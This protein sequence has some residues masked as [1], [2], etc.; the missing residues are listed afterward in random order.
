MACDP[1]T[2]ISSA[3]LSDLKK[4]ITTIDTVVESSLDT[5]VTKDGKTIN[6]LSGQLKLLGFIPPLVYTSGIVFTTSDT[7]KTVVE[8]G[9]VY[10]PNPAALPFTTSGTFIG[11]DDARFFVVQGLTSFSTELILSAV[12][13][14]DMKSKD[15]QSGQAI[16]TQGYGSSGDGGGDKYLIQT[17]VEFGG[18]PNE[19]DEITLNNGN[20]AVSLSVVLTFS[21]F[22]FVFGGVTDNPAQ[23]TAILNKAV[24]T[25]YPI[26]GENKLVRISGTSSL[27]PT[28]KF[29]LSN[30]N[31]I[32]GND[33]TDQ[34]N[35]NF[36]TDVEYVFENIVVDGERNTRAELEPWSVFSSFGGYDSI[37]P[38]GVGSF[39]KTNPY[40]TNKTTVKNITFNNCHYQECMEL[41]SYGVVAIDNFES[42][43]CSYKTY[44][45]W[46][47]PDAGSD[48]GTGITQANRITTRDCGVMVNDFLVDGVAKTRADAFA[49]QGA[50]GAIVTFGRYE[51][52]NVFV[53][54]YGS[55]G[56]TGD[57]NLSWSCDNLQIIHDDPNAFSNNPSGAYWNES[58]SRATGN[59]IE[60][61]VTARD[62]RETPIDNSLV[63]IYLEN[64]EVSELSDLILETESG[65]N[66]NKVIRGS[67]GIGAS[68]QVNN[69]SIEGTGSNNAIVIAGLGGQSNLVQL[70]NGR[71]RGGDIIIRDSLNAIVTNCDL[72]ELLQ[73]NDTIGTPI[74]NITLDN[75]QA[76]NTDFDDCSGIIKVNACDLGRI[77]MAPGSGSFERMTVDGGTH[78]IFNSIITG[79][80]EALFGDVI[81][82]RRVEFQDVERVTVSGGIYKTN[83]AEP[84]LWFNPSAPGIMLQATALANSIWIQTGTVGAVFI[85]FDVNV[86]SS[87][88]I[89]NDKQTFAWT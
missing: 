45:V 65:A 40:I 53:Y 38:L 29:T 42:S 74:G 32:T 54:N 67:F 69:F 17:A 35:I 49:P 24:T 72:N 25:G 7:T 27:S 71:S 3:E 1:S 26:D 37:Q 83:I 79:G 14:T 18:T 31:C 13:V 86:G 87:T 51:S 12:D 19:F 23:L 81:T 62:A 75:V 15:L 55:T 58:C 59:G 22:G 5:T 70:N 57:R 46:H 4:D 66:I 34:V 50:F 16:E 47:S 41:H 2:T 36:D 6:T 64:G 68:S 80:T 21:R 39:I 44:H 10:Y 63:Q 43:F 76:G 48:P 88:D 77:R 89:G 11:D 84:I 9:V 73:F 78:L 52:S 56:I 60:I 20:I 33:Y 82:E 85:D 8:A 28:S 61:K 30:I